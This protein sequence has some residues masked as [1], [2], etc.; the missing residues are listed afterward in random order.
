MPRWGL[1]VEQNIGFGSKNRMWSVG[2]MGQVEGTR[3]EALA[4][5]RQRAERFEPV[6]PNTP[7]RRRLYRDGDGFLMVLDG[8]WQTFHVRFSVAEQ[9][10]DSEESEPSNTAPEATS[11]AVRESRPAVVQ[12]PAGPVPDPGPP[13]PWD[14]DV[15]DL[16]SWWGRDDLA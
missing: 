11:A 1:I 5:L 3:E 7:K 2:V 13:K 10:F 16:P 9:L 8:A 4:E 12:E 14:A 15:P 6:H